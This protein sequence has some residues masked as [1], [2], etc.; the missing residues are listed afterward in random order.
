MELANPNPDPRAQQNLLVDRQASG[1]LVVIPVVRRAVGN[2]EDLLAKA[3][4]GSYL[5][6][7]RIALVKLRIRDPGSS[8]RRDLMGGGVKGTFAPPLQPAPSSRRTQIPRLQVFPIGA[9]AKNPL[10]KAPPARG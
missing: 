3:E 10:P 9:Y 8:T 5:P 1:L 4:I 6:R 2:I 7:A